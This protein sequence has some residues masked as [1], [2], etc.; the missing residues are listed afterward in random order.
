MG[1]QCLCTCAQA[2]W[3][4]LNLSFPLPSSSETPSHIQLKLGG[5]GDA[6]ASTPH[7]TGSYR[8][9]MHHTL[10]TKHLFSTMYFYEKGI[11]SCSK[12]FVALWY[13]SINVIKG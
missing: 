3:G 7:S 8:V 12:I 5:Q 4:V 10:P 11:L 9:H 6:P 1:D 2:T 13:L